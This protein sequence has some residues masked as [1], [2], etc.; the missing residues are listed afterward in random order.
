MTKRENVF[1]GDRLRE[2]REAL[3]LT[4]GELAVDA[5]LDVAAPQGYIS[6]LEAGRKQPSLGILCTLAKFF[7]TSSDYLLGMTDYKLPVDKSDNDIFL[8]ARNIEERNSLQQILDILSGQPTGEQM[9]ALTLIRKLYKNERVE[10][11][12]V[13]DEID[14]RIANLLQIVQ[15]IAG[16]DLAAEIK[17]RFLVSLDPINRE[18]T[19][20][21]PIS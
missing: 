16:G 11:P 2:I 17:T 4:Q 3:A 5:A 12:V 1:R 14:D 20:A 9:F 13:E 15:D 7:A 19:R 18:Q 21:E 8:R 10:T 6:A